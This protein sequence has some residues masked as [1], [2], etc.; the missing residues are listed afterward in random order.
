M[1][2]KLSSILFDYKLFAQTL[3]RK[4]FII[5]IEL[6]KEPSKAAVAMSDKR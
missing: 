6:T 4:I 1:F 3:M 2:F 5:A